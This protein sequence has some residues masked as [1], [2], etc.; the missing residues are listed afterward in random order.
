M[1]TTAEGAVAEPAALRKQGKMSEPDI[2]IVGA[3][4]AGICCAR[5]LNRHGVAARILEAADGIGGRVRSDRQEGFILDRGFQVLLTAYPEALEQ[6]DYDALGLRAFLS[7]ATIRHHGRFL[8]F[9][10]PARETGGLLNN[11]F[12]PIG[13]MADKYRLWKLRYDV[14]HSSIEEIFEAPETTTL[15]ALRQRG[16]STRMSETLFKPLLGGM[17]LDAKLTASSRLFEFLFKM[18]TEGDAALPEEGIGAIPAQLAKELPEGCIALNTRVRSAGAREVVLASG[19]ELRAKAVVM[20]TEGAEAARLLGLAH[21]I[22]SRSVS[23][24]YFTAKEPPLEEPIVVLNG[25]SRGP[26]NILCVPN[27]VQPSYAPAGEW[28]I[29]ATVLGWP[30][31][32]DKL[33]INS[34]RAQLRRWYGLVAQE[35]RLLRL[36]RIQN[37]HPVIYPLD[38]DQAPRVE[39]GL[40]CCGDHRATPSFQGAM[41]S[42]RRAAEALLGELGIELQPGPDQPVNSAHRRGPAGAPEAVEEDDD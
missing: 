37:A 35:W 23:V 2:L 22:N 42:G 41:M 6:L 5:T 18:L 33:L 36:Y 34:V 4:L 9:S 26:V 24:L 17:M 38:W 15:Q 12:L 7:G 1:K 3:G 32:D 8:R 20:A 25:G 14:A 30:T 31:S 27:L 29:S 13:S 40:Y 28:L 10:D 19:E 39:E 11:L 16:F 21:A